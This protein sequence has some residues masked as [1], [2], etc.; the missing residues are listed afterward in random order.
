MLGMPE[1][2]CG[3]ERRAGAVFLTLQACPGISI[4][5]ARRPIQSDRPFL[6]S[7]VDWVKLEDLRVGEET[8]DVLAKRGADQT[9]VEILR[10]R[11][12]RSSLRLEGIPRAPTGMDPAA[13]RAP[14]NGARHS[15]GD[16]HGE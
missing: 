1:V 12:P 2:L 16:R 7:F 3:F 14:G 4:R 15:E 11:R 13:S 10:G 8:I 9:D 6:P 5:A